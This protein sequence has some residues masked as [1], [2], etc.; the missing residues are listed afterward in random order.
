MGPNVGTLTAIL[1]DWYAK[2]QEELLLDIQS[3]TVT[4]L[5]FVW[6]N[7]KFSLFP[8]GREPDEIDVSWNVIIRNK[9]GWLTASEWKKWHGIW[10]IWES[11]PHAGAVRIKVFDFEG[12]SAPGLFDKTTTVISRL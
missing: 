5:S 7:T 3:G 4:K 1:N 6:E 12:R 10:S 8:I 9:Q 11:I 2:V